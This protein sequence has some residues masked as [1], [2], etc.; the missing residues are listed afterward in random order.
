MWKQQ[1]LLASVF[2]E[3]DGAMTKRYFLDKNGVATGRLAGKPGQTHIDIARTALA[4]GEYGPLVGDLYDQMFAHGFVRVREDAENVWVEHVKPLTKAQQ[5]YLEDKK[6]HERKQVHVNDRAFLESKEK[7][8]MRDVLG[9]GRGNRLWEMAGVF[10]KESGVKYRLF[11]SWG[12]Y[13]GK[14]LPHAVRFKIRVEEKEYTVPLDNP[15][16]PRAVSAR[17]WANVLRYIELNREVIRMF[18]DG[19]LT[20]KEFHNRLQPVIEEGGRR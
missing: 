1:A 12:E 18:W 5:Q 6:F 13:A 10:P 19:Q 15:V 14:K 16:C 4:G 20:D 3:R 2:K 9:L 8:I 17:E 11:F 7:K